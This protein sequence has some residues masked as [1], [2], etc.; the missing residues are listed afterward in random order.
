MT[1]RRT[2]VKNLMVAA[3]LGLMAAGNAYG[4]AFQ[5]DADCDE[6]S[7]FTYPCP[8][9]RKPGRKCSGTNYAKRSLCIADK[10]T[11]CGNILD[12]VRDG[13]IRSVA[14]DGNVIAAAER[15][16]WTSGN[17]SGVGGGVIGATI[18]IYGGKICAGTTVGAAP[19]MA[20][21]SVGAAA[22]VQGVCTQLC[23]DRHL[24]DCK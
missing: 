4:L 24:L 8:T 11:S 9:L 10:S 16:G 22:L 7:R 18:I 12:N 15:G 13:M 23:H 14:S 3:V 19:C 5:C 1:L 21:V 17:C 6:A 2:L 20:A